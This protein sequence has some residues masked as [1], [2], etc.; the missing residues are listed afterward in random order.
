M[1]FIEEGVFLFKN[2]DISSWE[3]IHQQIIKQFPKVEDLSFLHKVVP[4]KDINSRRL[5]AFHAVNKI[6][7]W[8][9]KYFSMGSSN[10]TNLIGPDILIQRKLNL[11]IQMPDDE[12]SQLGIHTDTMSGQSPFE[13]V[14]WT[15][16]SDFEKEAGMYYFDIETS[17]EMFNDLAKTEQMGVDYLREKYWQ[18]RKFLEINKG[19]VAI[20]TGSI[21]HGNIVNKT[22]KTRV[23][24][25]CRFKNIFSP[26]GLNEINERGVGVFYKLLKLS[27]LSKIAFKHNPMEIKF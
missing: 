21:F 19:E 2:E 13:V 16:F 20:F 9:G 6:I 7:D 5:Q 22:N 17:N 23:S 8:E 15:P 27:P 26:E 10:I 12:S 14:M 25:N 24:I 3:L 1:S 18:K 11:S 4:V